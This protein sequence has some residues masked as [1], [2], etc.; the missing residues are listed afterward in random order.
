MLLVLPAVEIT[1][2]TCEFGVDVT[3]MQSAYATGRAWGSEEESVSD[4]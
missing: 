1:H 2:L 4:S 3:W